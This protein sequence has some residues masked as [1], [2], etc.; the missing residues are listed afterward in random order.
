M[1]PFE[2]N[3][4]TSSPLSWQAP[5]FEYRE[6]GVSW[7]WLSIIIAV[8]M[9]SVAVWQKNF[10]FGFFVV[11]AE[12]LILAWANREPEMVNFQLNEKGLSIGG[13]KFYPYVDLESFSLEDD[14]DTEW[15]N[16]FL[17]FRRRLKPTLRIKLPKNRATEIQKALGS[18]LPQVEHEHSLLDTLEEFIRF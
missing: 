3:G 14:T 11:A 12:I 2:I 17:Q 16:V 6:K 5:E 10:L 4:S 13:Q 7:Y 8:V 15:P 1:S 18:A 9:L